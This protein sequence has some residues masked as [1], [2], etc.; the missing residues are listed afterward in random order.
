MKRSEGYLPGSMK[1]DGMKQICCVLRVNDDTI[2]KA[3][4]T[5][6]SDLLQ[7]PLDVSPPIFKRMAP[8]FTILSRESR[9]HEFSVPVVLVPVV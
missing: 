1:N 2:P 7:Y 4:S 8:E 9:D 6:R 5:Y 3:A